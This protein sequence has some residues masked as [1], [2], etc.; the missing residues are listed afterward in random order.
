MLCGLHLQLLILCCCVIFS[1]SESFP[2]EE[3][4]ANACWDCQCNLPPPSYECLCRELV[5]RHVS[6]PVQGSS[7]CPSSQITHQ[8]ILEI[9]S[10]FSIDGVKISKIG[11]NEN[12]HALGL[13]AHGQEALLLRESMKHLY[14]EG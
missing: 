13:L 14:L 10:S 7:D 9:N 11:W 3:Q 4:T 12:L 1:V 5:P 8:L 6:N 2:K